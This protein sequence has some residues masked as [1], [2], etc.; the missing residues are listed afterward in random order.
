SCSRMPITRSTCRRAPA[1]PM[2]SCAPRCW[3]RSPNGRRTL[4]PAAPLEPDER[5]DR[6]ERDHDEAEG[7]TPR[8]VQ[9]RHDLE[10][11][12]VNAGNDRRRNAHNRNDSQDLEQIVLRDGDEA[13]HG[14]E[15][16]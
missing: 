16:K 4:E 12:A 9:L 8:P 11:H 5:N 15:Q 10:I 13:E 7:I 3:I 6:A 1:A 14:V 2:R